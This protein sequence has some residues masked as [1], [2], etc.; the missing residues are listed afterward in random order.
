MGLSNIVFS[1]TTFATIFYVT[2]SYFD[3][4]STVMQEIFFG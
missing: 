2:V 3:P 1:V 4:R